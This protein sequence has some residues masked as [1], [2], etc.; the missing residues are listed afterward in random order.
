MGAQ[1]EL[2]ELRIQI[3]SQEKCGYKLGARRSADTCRELGE[4]RYGYGAVRSEDTGRGRGEVRIRVGSWEK[5]GYSQAGRGEDTDR[6]L[7]VVRTQVESWEQCRHRWG[8][9]RN[10]DTGTDLREALVQVGDLG[11]WDN[12][13]S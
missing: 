3:G 4:V 11:K 10:E 7:G 8:A 13:W 12:V 1:V 9:G 5:S 6:V 2:G